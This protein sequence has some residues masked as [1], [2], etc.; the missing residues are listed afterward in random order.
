[1]TEFHKV[2]YSCSHEFTFFEILFIK[3]RICVSLIHTTTSFETPLLTPGEDVPRYN[4]LKK[5]IYGHD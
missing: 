2:R 5:T 1:M 4:N 3:I